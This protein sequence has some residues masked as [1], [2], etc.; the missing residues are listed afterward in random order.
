[1]RIGSAFAVSAVV[2]LCACGGGGGGG[3]G[4]TC[5]PGAT[6]AFTIRSTGITPTA[7]CVLPS[8]TVSF[9]N[10]D[11]V[12]HTV[13]STDCAA[14]LSGL[15]SITANGGTATASFGTTQKTCTFSVN[16]GNAP[17]QGTIGVTSVPQQG[18]GY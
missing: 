2:A 13:T 1:M 8:G 3:G 12:A 14:E 6:A 10:A 7:V 17:F 11:A 5:N 15:G 4:G 16:P 18:P 9:N